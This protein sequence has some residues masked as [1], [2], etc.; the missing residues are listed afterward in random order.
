VREFLGRK[1]E[2]KIS[3]G[4]LLSH[5]LLTFE[6]VAKALGAHVMSACIR[7]SRLLRLVE[8]LRDVFLRWRID[9]I[10]LGSN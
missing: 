2:Y 3:I 6:L 4:V 10:L 8:L 5:M 1:I 7:I 9:A